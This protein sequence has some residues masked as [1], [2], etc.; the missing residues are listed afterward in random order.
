M[1]PENNPLSDTTIR[2]RTVDIE[3]E[4]TEPIYEPFIPTAW[5]LEAKRYDRINAKRKYLSDIAKAKRHFKIKKPKR[6]KRLK[7][8]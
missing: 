5:K 1:A 4:E 7:R 2:Y 6:L 8:L 3:I